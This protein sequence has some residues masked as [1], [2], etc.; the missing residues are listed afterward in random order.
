VQELCDR[1][2]VIHHGSLV[3]EGS[4]DDL[5]RKFSDVRR[6]RLTFDRVVEPNDLEPFGKVVESTSDTATIEVARSETARATAA[7]LQA[8]PVSDLGI[9]EVEIEEVIRDLFSQ[10]A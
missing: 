2:V 9:E 7:M 4:L 1:V 8:L 6:V 5:S 10:P 3:F